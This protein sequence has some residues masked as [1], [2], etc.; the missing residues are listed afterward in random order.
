MTAQGNVL[1]ERVHDQEQSSWQNGVL[2]QRSLPLRNLRLGLYGVADIVEF[3]PDDRGVCIAEHPGLF[4]PYPI[5]YK[6]GSAKMEDCDRAQLC[7]QALCLEEMLQVSIAEG[8]L[9]YGETRRR[10][11]VPL[12]DGLRQETQMLCA[13]MH[14]AF[15]QGQTPPPH[16]T[17]RC[18]SCSLAEYCKPKAIR[19]SAR[20]YWQS[21]LDN[22]RGEP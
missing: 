17:P 3:R 13:Q 19:K 9:F 21:Q 1:H 2:V 4:L 11:R 14:E 20:A 15:A 7:A 18:R 10:E 8:S 22:L 5:E 12:D 16:Y 6:R